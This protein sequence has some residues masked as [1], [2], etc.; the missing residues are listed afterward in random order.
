MRIQVSEALP[1]SAEQ[2]FLLIRDHMN[3]LVPYLYDIEE[4]RATERREE[5]DLVHIVNLWQGDMAQVPSAV[6]K[7]VKREL[8]SWIDYATWTTPTRSGTWRLEPRVGA[9]AFECSGTTA[10]VEDGE[11][12]VLEMDI[13]LVIHPGNVPGVPKFLVRKFQPQIEAAIRRQMEPNLRNLA[14]SVRSYVA[15]EG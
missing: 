13:E 9:R 6:R 11:T 10:L 5:G 7:F 3:K 12:C 2:A 1:M 15:A 8:F 4:I 14:I